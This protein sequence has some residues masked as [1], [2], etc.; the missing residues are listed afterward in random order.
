[1]LIIKGLLEGKE[2]DEIE[3]NMP[4]L[5]CCIYTNEDFTAEDKEGNTIR[6]FLKENPNEM[7]D[8]YENQRNS[9]RI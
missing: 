5:N 8:E 2:L 1:M 3:I 9:R 7:E 4:P 6:F